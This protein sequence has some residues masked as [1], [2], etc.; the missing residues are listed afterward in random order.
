MGKKKKKALYHIHCNTEELLLRL[1]SLEEQNRYLMGM[2]NKLYD[3]VTQ[4]KANLLALHLE[5]TQGVAVRRIP[6]SY[7]VNTDSV[8][9]KHE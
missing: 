6:K 9:V 8:E 7:A 4:V 2:V 1:V 5:A 3:E